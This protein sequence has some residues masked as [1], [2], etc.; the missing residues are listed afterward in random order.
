VK[1]IVLTDVSGAMRWMQ[2]TITCKILKLAYIWTSTRGYSVQE[3]STLLK[4]VRYQTGSAKKVNLCV[5]FC[6]VV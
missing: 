3:P 1:I 2:L 4:Q 5:D 6:R